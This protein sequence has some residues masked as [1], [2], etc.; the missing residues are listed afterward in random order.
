M[1]FESTRWP[2]EMHV[3]RALLQGPLDR[4]PTA[5]VFS[6]THVPWL[7][8]NDKLPKKISPTSNTEAP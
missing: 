2:G 4:E 3:A 5:H 8:V 6:E 7:D 1:F